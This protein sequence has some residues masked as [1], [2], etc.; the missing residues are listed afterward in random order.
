[1]SERSIFL[2]ALDRSEPAERDAYLA[3][4]CAGDAEMR[5]RVLALLQAHEQAGNF[6]ETPAMDAPMPEIDPTE[7]SPVL[8]RKRTHQVARV[9]HS[10]PHEPPPQE[11]NLSAAAPGMD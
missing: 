1:M 6:L 10:E 4:A 7:A 5:R 11:A 3:Q 2:E 9:P 8:R